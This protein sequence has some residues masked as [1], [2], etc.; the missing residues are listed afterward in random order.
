[1]PIHSKI[2]IEMFK[3]VI[4]HQQ[5][6]EEACTRSM[7]L[8][9]LKKGNKQTRIKDGIVWKNNE[10]YTGNGALICSTMGSHKKKKYM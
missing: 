2:M 8:H 4:N 6:H 5:I 9:W 3:N 10:G 7:Q 1:M